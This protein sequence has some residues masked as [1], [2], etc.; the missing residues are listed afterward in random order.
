[1]LSKPKLVTPWY[2]RGACLCEADE[3][4]ND[5]FIEENQV[6]PDATRLSAL[7]YLESNNVFLDEPPPNDVSKQ[8]KIEDFDI[9]KLRKQKNNNC[10]PLNRQVSPQVASSVYRLEIVVK[11]VQN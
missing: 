8:R 1:M 7:Q 10:R 2:A 9:T 6:I 4:G 5:Y 11:D 3:S